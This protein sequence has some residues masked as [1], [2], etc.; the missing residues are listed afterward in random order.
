VACRGPIPTVAQHSLSPVLANISSEEQQGCPLP[1]RGALERRVLVGPRLV[2]KGYEQI[3][4]PEDKPMRMFVTSTPQEPDDKP[5]C[6]FVMGTPQ[7][8]VT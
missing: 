8:P 5:A 7:E 6:M 1:W 4:Q 3:L 2:H